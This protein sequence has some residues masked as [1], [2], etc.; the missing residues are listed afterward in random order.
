MRGFPPKVG[1]SK[2]ESHIQKEE[3]HLKA[4]VER[5]MQVSKGLLRYSLKVQSIEIF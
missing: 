5:L 3:E 1:W 4:F 2:V